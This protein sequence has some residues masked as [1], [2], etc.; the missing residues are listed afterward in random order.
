MEPVV[1]SPT[2][3]DADDTRWRRTRIGRGGKGGAHGCGSLGRTVSALVQ[4][5]TACCVSSQRRA[6][7]ASKNLPVAIPFVPQFHLVHHVLH[8][9]AG[10]AIVAILHRYAVL[11]ARIAIAVNYQVVKLPVWH[12]TL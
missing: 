6:R 7:H 2:V 11:L 12:R 10:H 9:N 8:R 1:L 5:N 3:T 4:E